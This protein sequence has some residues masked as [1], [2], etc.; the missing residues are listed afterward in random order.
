[1]FLTRSYSR[2]YAFISMSHIRICTNSLV[3]QRLFKLGRFDRSLVR[4]LK[5]VWSRLSQV[6]SRFIRCRPLF[7]F[8]AVRSFTR[9]LIGQDIFPYRKCPEFLLKSIELVSWLPSKATQL[10]NAAHSLCAEKDLTAFND[11]LRFGH[12]W[13]RRDGQ[14]LNDRTR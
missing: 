1:M 7:K 13:P 8:T 6:C 9:R 3:L 4:V 11:Q 2:S 14:W 5:F 12:E 10:C